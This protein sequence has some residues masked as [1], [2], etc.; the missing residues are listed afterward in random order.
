MKY[1]YKVY[2]LFADYDYYMENKE[3][4]FESCDVA[5]AYNFLTLVK[6][7]P[8]YYHWVAVEVAK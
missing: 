7:E 6:D 5:D 1:K 3:L 4:L 8:Y 2:E